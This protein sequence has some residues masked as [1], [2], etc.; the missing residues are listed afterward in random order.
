MSERDEA[1]RI[2]KE[3]SRLE[4]KRRRLAGKVMEVKPWALEEDEQLEKRILELARRL[5]GGGA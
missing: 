4:E 5:Q 1:R 2:R 3:I